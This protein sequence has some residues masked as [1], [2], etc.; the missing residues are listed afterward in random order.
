LGEVIQTPAPAPPPDPF[1]VK[2]VE[3]NSDLIGLADV[4]WGSLGLTGVLV[5]GSILAAIVFA[6]VLFW[7][8][9]RQD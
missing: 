4:L 3:P 6:G 8:R 7:I 9:S 2:I 1:I 5:L